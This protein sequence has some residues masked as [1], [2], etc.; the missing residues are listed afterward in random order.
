M[1]YREDHTGD[2]KE[3][4]EQMIGNRRVKEQWEKSLSSAEDVQM[5]MTAERFQRQSGKPEHRVKWSCVTWNLLSI[6]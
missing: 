3:R 6:I 2:G 4:K 1:E 5:R